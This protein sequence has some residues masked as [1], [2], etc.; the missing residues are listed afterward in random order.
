MWDSYDGSIKKS[1]FVCQF[2]LT[3][4]TPINLLDS[5]AVAGNDN[6]IYVFS[7][8]TGT[9]IQQI[10]AHDDTITALCFK[11]VS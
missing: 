7:F 4:A 8:E 11:K 3:S 5:F 1:F 2:G 6:N 9:T 10:Y